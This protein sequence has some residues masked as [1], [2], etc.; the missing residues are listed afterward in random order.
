MAKQTAEYYREYRL[1]NLEKIRTYKRAYDNKKYKENPEKVE[2]RHAKWRKKNPEK[3]SAHQKVAYVLRIGKLIKLPCER[4]GVLKVH[5][6]HSDYSK[7]L[8]VMWL[9]HIHHKEWHQTSRAK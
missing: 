6:H 5:A 7:P 9:C 3:Y 1:K 8:E 2:A 4:C